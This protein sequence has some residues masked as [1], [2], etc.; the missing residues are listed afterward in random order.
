MKELGH[1]ALYQ[2][3][4]P[5]EWSPGSV[6]QDAEVKYSGFGD[7]LRARLAQRNQRGDILLACTGVIKKSPFI[8]NMSYL[9]H[10][11]HEA[12]QSSCTSH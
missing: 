6:M 8:S 5:S 11:S 3:L 10:D 9:E 2:T 12:N 4:R 7:R 1:K